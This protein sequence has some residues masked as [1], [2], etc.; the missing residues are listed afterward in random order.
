MNK[1]LIII[2]GLVILFVGYMGFM[3]VRKNKK[4]NGLGKKKKVVPEYTQFEVPLN[5]IE[6]K[7]NS[8]ELYTEKGDRTWWYKIT[9]FFPEKA[10]LEFDFYSYSDDVTREYILNDRFYVNDREIL[11]VD[12]EGEHYYNQ[13]KIEKIDYLQR[14]VIAPSNIE[15]EESFEDDVK[16]I[17]KETFEEIESVHSKKE[18]E[19]V[20]QIEI[21]DS[22]EKKD[23]SLFEDQSKKRRFLKKSK[24]K[25][26]N[27]K[28]ME[29]KTFNWIFVGVICFMVFSGVFALFRTFGIGGR[30]DVVQADLSKVS[31]L[32]SDVTGGDAQESY[33]FELNEFMQKFIELYVPV[34]NDNTAM[35]ERAEKL[36]D[37]LSSNVSLDK[38]ISMTTR[39]LISSELNNIEKHDKF[40]TAQYKVVYSLEIPH[41]KN[42]EVT[43]DKKVNDVEK[44]PFIEY[45][46]QEKTTF[47]NVDYVEK[48]NKFSIVSY[49]YFSVSKKLTM[50]NEGLSKNEQAA[51]ALNGDQLKE[52]ESFLDI[53]LAKYASGST[54]ELQYLMKSVES[55]GD[56]YELKDVESIE[57]FSHKDYITVYTKANFIE[58]SSKLPHK[59]V[60][61]LKLVKE[62][63]QY[64]I[65]ELRHNLGG[66]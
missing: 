63:N 8:K 36:K 38:E 51:T 2:L 37:Y 33:P 32:S 66:F 5:S 58:K 31:K 20:S 21:A 54:E 24:V 12:E 23:Q 53:F 19:S 18:V 62:N 56:N 45:E 29:A 9:I 49:P 64:K 65:D 44:E 39:K 7:T 47:L 50:V 26:P 28:K 30:L 10:P 1:Q 41:E 15:A 25:N 46:T 16:Q 17:E 14:K 34:S 52:V 13:N 27:I 6:K 4:R 61:S 35:D 55:L 42:K 11:I 22:F 48:D 57:V 3:F 40:T 60:F 43:T 59:E